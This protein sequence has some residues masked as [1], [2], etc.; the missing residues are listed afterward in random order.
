MFLEVNQYCSTEGYKQNYAHKSVGSEECGIKSAQVI[1]TNQRVL[2]EQ[3]TAGG[4][5]AD[6][7]GNAQVGDKVKCYES[8]ECS[9]MEEPRNPK[10]PADPKTRRHR[11]EAFATIKLKILTSVKNIETRRPKNYHQ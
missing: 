11:I 5:D 9:K 6:Q 10:S 7:S 3:Q 4:D 2:I 1:G 8:Q